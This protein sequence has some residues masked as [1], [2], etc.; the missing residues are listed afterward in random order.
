[1]AQRRVEAASHLLATGYTS[2]MLGIAGL[3]LLACGSLLM[4]VKAISDL[5]QGNLPGAD[6]ATA[7]RSLKF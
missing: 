3:S 4:T 5:E 1:V 7:L 6:V 2:T